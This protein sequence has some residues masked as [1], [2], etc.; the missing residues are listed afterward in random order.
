MAGSSHQ[1]YGVI[2]NRLNPACVHYFILHG[3]MVAS[4][5]QKARLTTPFTWRS[6]K[7][8]E[9]LPLKWSMIVFPGEFLVPI[10]TQTSAGMIADIVK[11]WPNCMHFLLQLMA[12]VNLPCQ[13]CSVPSDKPTPFPD[14]TCF[15]AIHSYCILLPH[16]LPTLCALVPLDWLVL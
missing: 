8:L 11:K 10:P 14:C 2:S 1:N 9:N 4:A 6:R 13:L 5:A 16:T 3:Q 7:T 12:T 15:H